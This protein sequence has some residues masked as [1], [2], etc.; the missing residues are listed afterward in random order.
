MRRI[1]KS[2]DMDET[3]GEHVR[4]VNDDKTVYVLVKVIL[5]SIVGHY[6]APS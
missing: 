4:E 2:I 3:K 6:S 5:I 1:E